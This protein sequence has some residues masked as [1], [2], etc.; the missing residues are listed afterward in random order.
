M[1]IPYLITLVAVAS[2][3]LPLPLLLATLPS[4]PL[5]RKL[6]LFAADNHMVPERIRP[7]KIIAT[8]WHIVYGL[9]LVL[10]LAGAAVIKQLPF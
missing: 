5:A 7:L 2:S 1:A 4:L 3:C 6:T 9:C 8:K 10:G